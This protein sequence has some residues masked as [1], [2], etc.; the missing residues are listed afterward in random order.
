LD[1]LVIILY[2][3]QLLLLVGVMAVHITPKLVAPVV[4]VA[5]VET[6]LLV[7][8]QPQDRVVMAVLE[9]PVIMVLAAV[10]R[11]R[12]AAMVKAVRVVLV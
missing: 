1:L 8:R 4:Q 12:L 6:L 3:R 11:V 10:A 7:V 2:F 5:V 9:Q